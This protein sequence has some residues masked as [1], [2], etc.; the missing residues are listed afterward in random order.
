VQRVS[1]LISP[2]AI[3]SIAMLA[4]MASSPSAQEPDAAALFKKSCASCHDGSGA[5]RAPAPEA[6]KARS[7]EA[8]VDAL[9]GGAMRY[10]GLSLGGA[11][12]RALAEYLTGKKIGG[13][14]TGVGPARCTAN[15]P[16]KD[17][18]TTS[19]WNGWGPRTAPCT[20]STRRAAACTG[21]SRHKEAFARPSRLGAGV[22]LAVMSRAQSTAPISPTRRASPT[23][24]MPQQAN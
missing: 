20:R 16:M 18:A 1:R 2:V 14:L 8:I 21:R 24:W 13:D 6:L 19:L 15:T 17:P 12:R 9:T 11:E 7:P 10:Q 22:D 4:S 23:P 5:T 3:L